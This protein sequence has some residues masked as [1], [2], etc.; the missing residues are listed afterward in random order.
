MKPVPMTIYVTWTRHMNW[1]I[2][3]QRRHTHQTTNAAHGLPVNRSV[4]I[5]M[6]RYE[7]TGKH[8]KTPKINLTVSHKLYRSSCNRH[9]KSNALHTLFISLKC[10]CFVFQS[11]FHFPSFWHLGWSPTIEKDRG[12]ESWIPELR[13]T[14][15]DSA[16]D[17]LLLCWRLMAWVN[18]L[19]HSSR[20]SIIR[21]WQKNEWLSFVAWWFSPKINGKIL[22]Y[23]WCDDSPDHVAHVIGF[24]L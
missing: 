19:S 24:T 17:V 21:S 10:A 16:V 1:N 2:N 13:S 5:S 18:I 4:W 11:D 14:R 12:G 6:A 9:D 20:V 7:G 22:I 15:S 8:D 23:L 3:R